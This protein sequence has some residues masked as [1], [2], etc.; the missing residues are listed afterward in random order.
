MQPIKNGLNEIAQAATI[1]P[2]VLDKINPDRLSERILDSVGFPQ[3]IMNSDDE[4]KAIRDQQAEDL[5]K[6]EALQQAQGMA[7]AMPKLSKKPEEGSPAELIG[8]QLGV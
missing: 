4:V 3:D 6:A 8:Q 1:F 5:A 7:D 2:K